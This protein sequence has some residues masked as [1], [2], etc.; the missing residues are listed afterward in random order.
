MLSDR[1]TPTRFGRPIRRSVQPRPRQSRQAR[2]AEQD[3]LAA[4]VF[5][6]QKVTHKS[7]S[8][9]M[10]SR[11]FDPKSEGTSSLGQMMQSVHA[12][13]RINRR[14]IFFR[15]SQQQVRV[16]WRLTASTPRHPRSKAIV[17]PG[18]DL[19]RTTR[20]YFAGFQRQPT[21][22]VSSATLRAA[23]W[24]SGPP[25]LQGL[26]SNRFFGVATD[27]EDEQVDRRTTIDADTCSDIKSPIGHRNS[28][29]RFR[30]RWSEGVPPAANPTGH[31]HDCVPDVSDS[32]WQ[33]VD[34]SACSVPARQSAS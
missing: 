25:T 1:L 19:S 4:S 21:V 15:P 29:R 20:S 8:L 7:M 27:S 10:K 17:D 18:M 11:W 16:W 34:A 23:G 9:R 12:A 3:R 28:R 2:T 22:P 32:P 31:V 30:L 26:A 14:F 24:Q 33:A 6:A 5:T 13:E